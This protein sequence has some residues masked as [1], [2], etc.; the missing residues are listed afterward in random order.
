MDS[1]KLLYPREHPIIIHIDS[2]SLNKCLEYKNKLA[3]KLLD[4]FNASDTLW[5]RS[6]FR[7]SLFNKDICEYKLEEVSG[8]IKGLN[9]ET[10]KY[11]MQMA[12]GYKMKD[13]ERI[14]KR[15]YS[16]LSIPKKELDSVIRVFVQAVFNNLKDNN[17]YLTEDETILNKRFWFE[18][19]FPGGQLNIMN[20]EEFSLFFDLFLKENKKYFWAKYH[21]SNKG[22]W[23][24]LSTLEKVPS[25]KGN[26]SDIMVASA[27]TRFYYSLMA[28]D[29]MGLQFYR[30]VNN[31]T[32]DNSLYHFNYLLTLICGI[33]DNLALITDK[34]LGINTQ[35]KISV[36][37]NNRR[38][39]DFLKEV[40]KKNNLLGAHI[41]KNRSF[42]NLIHELR[43]Q[44]VHKEGM[45]K[46]AYEMRDED[47]KWKY[48]FLIVEDK[49]KNRLKEL[50][51][52]NKKYSIL[53]EWGAYH[54]HNSTY[55]EPWHFSLNA[56]LHLSNLLNEY[57]PLV[58]VKEQKTSELD[59]TLEN[60]SKTHIGY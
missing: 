54:A 57:L 8:E 14:A 2:E 13:I 43:D 41:D 27:Y 32:M 18:S 45:Q 26:L 7:S 9:Y 25:F 20:L 52:K 5:I 60:F 28:L 46:T 29:E 39:R 53:S 44:I 34:I 21:T 50:K 3:I 51:D 56:I 19:H 48:N 55:I 47:L 42:I 40:R 59:T 1:R 4:F 11:K 38:S 24:H 10:N 12:F 58:G 6:E 17:I 22:Y 49:T 15:I 23:Y 37:L 36:S 35:N 31:D 33:F 16:K 30:G